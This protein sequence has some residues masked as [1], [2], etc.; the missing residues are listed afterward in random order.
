MHI[1]PKEY[2]NF[3]KKDRVAAAIILSLT[4]LTTG[5]IFFYRPPNPSPIVIK[6]LDEELAKKGIDTASFEEQIAYVPTAE[7][8]FA[9]SSKAIEF[10]QFDPNTLDA[11]GFKR[12]GLQDK[13]INTILKYRS[14]GGHFWKADDLRKIYGFQKE[15]LDK[16]IPYV[17][18]AN[19]QET[20][21]KVPAT[22]PHFYK[23]VPVVIDINTAT[24]DQWKTLPAIGE[25]LANR[26]IKFRDKIGGFKSVEQ[27]KQTYGLSDTAFNAIKQYLTVTATAAPLVVSAPKATSDKIN[28]NTA[29]LNQ[30]KSNPHIPEEIAQAIIIYRSQHGYFSAI[31]EVKKIIFINEEMY[32]QIMP[33]ITVE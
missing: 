17:Q 21:T 4:V 18:I 33:Y 14:K 1:N 24:A 25:V 13:T 8:G 9:N 26:I 16:L 20:V 31:A 5:I 15:E 30:L 29:S 23:S 19:Q 11:A 3:S 7:A 2:L 27:V 28:I 6:T 12:L 22:Q 10:F 32:R